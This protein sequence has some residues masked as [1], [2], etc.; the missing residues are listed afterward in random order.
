[1][2]IPILVEP[3]ANNGYRARGFEPLALS[4]EGPTREAAVARL[5]EQLA[6]HLQKNGAS[7]VPLEIPEEH[8][9]AKF[10]GMFKDDPWIDDW[11]QAMAEYRRSVDA[12]PDAL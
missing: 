11:K 8:P 1:M 10:A 12:D 6:A 9:L 2:Q 4:A 5:K 7:M 3:V